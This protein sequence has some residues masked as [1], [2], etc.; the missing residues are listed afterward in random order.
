MEGCSGAVWVY[1]VES[2]VSR[3][4]ILL[5]EMLI[6]VVLIVSDLYGV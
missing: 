1:D 6:Q 2:Y 4:L 5:F 3:F